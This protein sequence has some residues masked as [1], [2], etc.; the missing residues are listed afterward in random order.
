MTENWKA[1]PKFEGLYEVSDLGNVRS[2]DR[3]EQRN[4]STTRMRKGKILSKVLMPDGYLIVRLSKNGVA[5]NFR[6]SRVVLAAFVSEPEGTLE[7]CHIDSNTLNNSAINLY[8][9]TRL[10]NE[11]DKDASGG[12]PKG[13]E[14]NVAVLSDS[15]VKYAREQV[16]VFG[17]TVADVARELKTRHDTLW[18]AVNKKTW[19]HV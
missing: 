5:K 15:I 18:L 2:L 19:R 11:K 7:A 10:E 8:W 14:T 6:V 3:V 9:G 17:R 12:R 4:S 1:I 13:V 16:L